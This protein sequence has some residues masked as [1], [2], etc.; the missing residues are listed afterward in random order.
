MPDAKVLSRQELHVI[1]FEDRKIR[2]GHF[3][4]GIDFDTFENGAKSEPVEQK[5]AAVARWV[6]WLP[7]NPWFGPARL[8]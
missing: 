6:S 1:R 8:Q 4:I 3:P 2:V 5:I 7:V